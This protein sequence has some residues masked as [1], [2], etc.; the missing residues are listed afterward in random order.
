MNNVIIAER[1]FVEMKNIFYALTHWKKGALEEDAA[2]HYVE[3]IIREIYS[4]PEK[5]YH[6]NAVYPEHKKYGNKV[7]KYRRN[8]HTTWYI[9]YNTDSYNN[10]FVNKIISNHTTTA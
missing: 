5:F 8:A 10:I 3:D 6:S 9:I 2:H 7:H 1:V 4:I